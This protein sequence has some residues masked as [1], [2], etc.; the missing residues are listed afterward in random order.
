MSAALKRPESEERKECFS[1]SSIKDKDGKDKLGK[2]PDERVGV[3]G[4]RVM[5]SSLDSVA[6]WCIL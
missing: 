1:K 4:E 2:L 6:L 3:E 5:L